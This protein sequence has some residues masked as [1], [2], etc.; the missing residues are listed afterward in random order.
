MYV[1]RIDAHKNQVVIGPKEALYSSTL[2]AG[3]V[4]WVSGQAPAPVFECQI[5]IR[6]L[7]LPAQA[8]VTVQE[9]GSILAEFKEPQLSVTAGQ[10]AV[11]YEGDTVL[12][13]GV[14]G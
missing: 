6:N 11:L 13:G 1:V 3:A 12:G 8:R 14:I 10:S 5:K 9:D 7:H 4:S 2:R